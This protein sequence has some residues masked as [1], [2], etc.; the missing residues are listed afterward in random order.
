MND[1]TDDCRSL[2]L[3]I[4]D[5][6]SANLT[7]R[8]S[9]RVACQPRAIVLRFGLL[10]Q[11]NIGIGVAANQPQ[12]AAVERPVKV[13]DLFRFKV[14]DL[15][16]RRTVERLQPEVIYSLISD[17][18]NNGLA[19]RGETHCALSQTRALQNDKFGVPGRIDW[20]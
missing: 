19:I 14:G 13:G 16:S 5:G 7:L 9:V 1:G 3:T 17:R 20:D 4:L 10:Q 18:I 15:P 6:W 2:S 8:G 12:L 11:H